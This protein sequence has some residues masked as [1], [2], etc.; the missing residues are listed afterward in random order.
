MRPTT[1]P[2]ESRISQRIARTAAALDARVRL[3]TGEPLPADLDLDAF[4]RTLDNSLIEHFTYQTVQSRAFAMGLLTY[5]EAQT[6]YVALGE[7]P[8]ED[9]WA[10][11]TSLATKLVVTQVL[12]ELIAKGVR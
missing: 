9:G 11:G 3:D 8:A 5:E 6:I 4:A 7:V 12:A 10:A 2:G 1:L